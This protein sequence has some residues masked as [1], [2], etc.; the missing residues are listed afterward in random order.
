VLLAIL[1]AAGIVFSLTGGGGTDSPPLA[2]SCTTPAVAVGSVNN[3]N[4]LRYS[5]T[6]PA[7]AT[8]VVTIDAATARIKGDGVDLTPPS[9]TAVAIKENLKNCKGNGALPSAE[10]SGH[11]LVIFRDGKVVA[12]AKIPG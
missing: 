8:Y 1:V 5:I 12:R 4:N 7:A 10:G 11:E 9:A 2:T 6:G 3:S